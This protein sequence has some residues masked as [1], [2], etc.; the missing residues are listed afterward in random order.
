MPRQALLKPRLKSNIQRKR[1]PGPYTLAL[2]WLSSSAIPIADSEEKD[3]SSDTSKRDKSIKRDSLPSYEV[4]GVGWGSEPSL[5]PK[6]SDDLFS[7]GIPPPFLSFFVWKVLKN[8]LSFQRGTIP[9]KS[10]V[11]YLI[12]AKVTGQPPAH[13]CKNDRNTTDL[14]QYVKLNDQLGWPVQSV[15]SSSTGLHR[16][17]G[18][19]ESWCKSEQETAQE[20]EAGGRGSN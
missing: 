7:R 13:V 6:V 12:N 14:R 18:G 1:S 11:R 5:P 16:W 8:A 17:S 10:F 4:V 3:S 20:K 2:I 9:I 15:S 19:I